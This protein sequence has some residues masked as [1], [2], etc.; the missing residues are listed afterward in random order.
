[1]THLQLLTNRGLWTL[2]AAGGT[3]MTYV[4]TI[5]FILVSVLMILVVLVQ[6]GRGG[7]VAGAF[8]GGGGQQSAFGTKTGDVFTTITV[9]LF[10]LFI[11]FSIGL[12]LKLQNEESQNT[13]HAVQA[14]NSSA[15]GAGS[16]SQTPAESGKPV[17]ETKPGTSATA[18]AATDKAPAT[19]PATTPATKP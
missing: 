6:R 14:D 16:S 13:S 11:G 12:N 2:A 5:A 17:E 15:K 3:T 7:G 4:L 8:G 9:I 18:A 1:M 10:I 19:L